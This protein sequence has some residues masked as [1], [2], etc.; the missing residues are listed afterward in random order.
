MSRPICPSGRDLRHT[1]P[2]HTVTRQQ[3]KR[4]TRDALLGAA[5]E[6]MEDRSFGSLSLREVTRGAGVTPTTFY[7]HFDSMEELG[8]VIVGESFRTLRQTIREAR[9]D[10]RAYENAIVNSVAVL[11]G[12]AREHRSHF[13]FIARERH[14][15]APVLRAAIRN[16][17]RLF[18]TELSTDLVRFPFLTEWST[19]D[20]QMMAALIVDS[21]VSTLEDLLDVAP[22][23]AEGEREIMHVAE[24]R[25][26]LIALGVPAWRAG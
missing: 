11:A 22:G 6:L 15:G 4:L 5:L 19:E 1:T 13:R 24:K 2:V 26:R 18:A 23:D 3:R 12:H 7:R 14:T 20:L 21:M 16:E 25:L 9:S 10:G 17:I 8:L